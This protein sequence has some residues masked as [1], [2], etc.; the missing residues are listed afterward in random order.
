MKKNGF[1]LA[2][3]LITLAII[4]VVASLT[5]PALMT[6]TGEQQYKTALRKVIN[7]LSEAGQMNAS[8]EGFDYAG[9]TT[10]TENTIYDADG[11]VIQSLYALLQTR[12]HV[13]DAAADG[14]AGMPQWTKSVM[15]FKDGTAILFDKS[16]TSSINGM[17][18]GFLVVIDAN[19]KKGPNVMSNCN[20]KP[21]IVSTDVPTT[22]T[23]TRPN[24]NYN[25]RCNKKE[26]RMIKDRFIIKLQDGLA[27]P[28]D[29]ASQW[30][31][32]N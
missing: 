8:L 5:L 4:G 29:D 13:V 24:D 30:A 23:D 15:Y 7:T 16:K 31:M 21:A 1:T 17:A 26:N 25:S 9:L 18:D 6:N 19:G 28:Y 20:K 14:G 12:T 22:F 32:E 2:E 27:E 3:V 10:N 11:N